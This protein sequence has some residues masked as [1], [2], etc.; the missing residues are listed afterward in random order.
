MDLSR[1]EPQAGGSKVTPT[2]NGS[3]LAQVRTYGFTANVGALLTYRFSVAQPLLPSWCWKE[4][5][6]VCRLLGC[7][8]G[9]LRNNTGHLHAYVWVCLTGTL[10]LRLP[11]RPKEGSPWLTP[12]STC[13]SDAY[14]VILPISTWHTIVALNMPATSNYYGVLKI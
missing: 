2:Q 7:A 9:Q 8:I 5:A 14:S 13:Q 10:L 4:R 12:V 3:L 1:A 6:L 11:G